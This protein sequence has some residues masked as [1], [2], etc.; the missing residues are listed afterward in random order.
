VRSLLVIGAAGYL[1]QSVVA[2]A[3]GFDRIIATHHATSPSDRDVAWRW[4]DVR[5]GAAIA[6]V[7]E[8]VAPDVIV[9][10]AYVQRGDDLD[11]VT[12]RAPGLIAAAA[13]TVGT[14]FVHISSDVLFAGRPGGAYREDD[15]PSPVYEYGRAKVAADRAVSTALPDALIVR[16]SL[17]YGTGLGRPP[18]PGPQERLV[19]DAL[20]GKPIRFFTDEVR[21]P[22]H[23]DVLA[24]AILELIELDATGLYHVA[25]DDAVDRLTFA[26]LLAAAMGADPDRLAGGA[27]DPQLGPRPSDVSLDC[28]KAAAVLQRTGLIGVRTV[29]APAW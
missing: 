23:V 3:V 27:S 21:N 13:A 10:C 25:G 12:A 28:A 9:N 16:T 29:L 17:L 7:V 4:L 24:D 2:R 14:R 22:L 1:G 6:R 18:R 8:S 15:S 11:A 20:G 26:R 5:D 19:V